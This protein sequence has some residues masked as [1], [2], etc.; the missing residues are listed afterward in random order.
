M[1]PFHTHTHTRT[2]TH[3]HSLLCRDKEQ[4]ALVDNQK[5]I[6]GPADRDLVV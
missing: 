6:S 2:H 4:A 5:L 1:Q 3:T